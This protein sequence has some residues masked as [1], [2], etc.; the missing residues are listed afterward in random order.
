MPMGRRGLFSVIAGAAS[1]WVLA[2][3]DADGGGITVDI[4]LGNDRPDSVLALLREAQAKNIQQVKENGLGGV[5]TV[6]A[7]I[8][9]AKGLADLIVRLL[10]MWQCGVRVDAR[11]ARVLTERDYDLPRGTVLVINPDGMRKTLRQPSAP[12]IQSLAE[13]FARR[14]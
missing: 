11:A 6:V 14:K 2:A 10:P 7:G 9:L 8:L 3:E 5:E 4:N 13:N 12:Q 1:S